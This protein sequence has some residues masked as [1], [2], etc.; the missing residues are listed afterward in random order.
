VLKRGTPKN[1]YFS[2]IS[3]FSVKTVADSTNM[4]LIITS[5]GEVHFSGINTDDLE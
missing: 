5:T 1:G 2:A 3:L 4:L